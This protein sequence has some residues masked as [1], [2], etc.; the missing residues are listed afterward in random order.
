MLKT[1]SAPLQM[2]S[3]TPGFKQYVKIVVWESKT[4]EILCSNGHNQ[5]EITTVSDTVV[6]HCEISYNL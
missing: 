3:S 1:V 6:S 2:S 4:S 5:Q